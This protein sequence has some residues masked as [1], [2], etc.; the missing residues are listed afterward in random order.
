M[1]RQDIQGQTIEIYQKNSKI[2]QACNLFS[3]G[4][5]YK[6]RLGNKVSTSIIA[7][8]MAIP[9]KTPK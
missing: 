8:N 9:V 7:K 4:L 1:L 2:D 6:I 3:N 5:I